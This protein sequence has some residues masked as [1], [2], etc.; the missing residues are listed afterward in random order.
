MHSKAFDVLVSSQ[1]RDFQ[2]RLCFV[3]G[4]DFASYWDFDKFC[5]QEYRLFWSCFLDWS[6]LPCDGASHPVCQGEDCE[7]AVFFPDLRLNYAECL[8][9]GPPDQPVL[10]A[11]HS[12]DPATG[13]SLTRGELRARVARLA[14]A[15]R[16]FG[17]QPGDRVAAIARNN[18]EVIVVA[19]AAAAVGAVLANCT[20]EMGAFAMQERLAPLA[21][22]LV[23]ANLQPMTWDRCEPMAER[24]A[25]LLAGLPGVEALVALDDGALP[26]R[27]GIPLHRLATLM[28]E[29]AEAWHDWPRLPFNHPLCILFS[30]GTTGRPKCIQHGA[31]G[32][33]IE[34][35]KEHRLHCDLGPGD[36]LFFQTSCGWMMWNWQLSALA[37]GAEILVHDGPLESPARFWEIVASHRVTVFGTNPAYLQHCEASGLEPGRSHDLAGLRLMLSTGS[38]LRP[39]QY[40]WVRRAVKPVPLHSISGGTDIIGCFVLGNPLL[41]VHAGESPCRSLGLDVR[42]LPE[43]G[44]AD[45]RSGELVCAN[46]FPSRPLGFFGEP[47][48]VRFHESYY[49]ANPGFWTHGDL[50]EHTAQGGWKVLGRSDS[51]LKI[52]GIR[53]GP[54]EIY[55]ILESI[56][57]IAEAMAVAQ[58]DEEE[59]GG[60]RLVLLV[61]LQPGLRL[62]QALDK[63]IR[64]E[65]ARRGAAHLVPGRILQVGALPLT[66]SG[67]R[68]EAAARDA[69]NNR[70]VRNRD[71]LRNPECLAPI[72]AAARRATRP[73]QASGGTVAPLPAASMA[74]R[75]TALCERILDLPELAPTDNLL[76]LG[77]DSLRMLS[78]LLAVEQSFGL[79]LSMS[80]LAAAPTIAGLLAQL[81]DRPPAPALAA[82]NA[83]R[84][85]PATAADVEPLCRFLAEGFGRADM[86]PERWRR[87]F[88][89]GWSDGSESGG[90][91]LLA[92]ETIV[93][94]IGTVRARHPLRGGARLCNLS[95]WYVHP[96][97]RGWGIALL[98]AALGEEDRS[99]TSFTPSTLSQQ[100]FAALDFRRLDTGRLFLPPLAH[101]GTLAA[102]GLRI[103]CAPE[104]VRSLLDPAARQVF[105]DHAPFGCLQMVAR[106]AAEQ[107]YLVFKRRRQPLPG[108]LGRLP[109]LLP[110]SEL[111]YCSA[112]SVLAR[113]LERI[114]LTV[115]TRQRTLG[116]VVDARLWAAPPRGL[117][118]SNHAVFRSASLDASAVDKLYSELVLL[119]V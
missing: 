91:L 39:R 10:T 41:P 104:V 71:A 99:W 40:D 18:A 58:E 85:R 70:P 60:Q 111:L 100:A 103:D 37:A 30:S 94:F 8:L 49:A 119:P 52:R 21:P 31:G 47:D 11:C 45:R 20:P 16:R 83:P 117:G 62:D 50:V 35:L 86:P 105:D 68:S 27:T 76:E 92:G 48:G 114:K 22:R 67:K 88:E 95:S 12:S 66:L 75:L 36:R 4:R 78:L 2:R 112:P 109:V 118:M 42:A 25:D 46:P 80:A 28:Q 51:L 56:V 57:E 72:A 9:R 79:S 74:A 29:D 81:Q 54:G 97:Y 26:D 15:L 108:R 17:I 73:A 69:V 53:V 24:V 44:A 107:A 3:A 93:G 65:L 106:D 82:P 32:T 38:V 98:V 1:M 113:H 116:L 6:M 43:P 63:R 13:S 96:D 110:Y 90:M 14:A 55:A 7:N 87:L 59:P 84:I 19:L 23:F 102:R 101:P 115:L 64:A 61:V 77:A 5:A 89:H 34:H 33:L